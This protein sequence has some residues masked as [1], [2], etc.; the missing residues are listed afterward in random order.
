MAAQTLGLLRE[1]GQHK[2][3]DV[4]VSTV[5]IVEMVISSLL[6]NPSIYGN[7]HIYICIYKAHTVWEIRPW[8]K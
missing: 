2:V 6:G 5:A 1:I 3:L 8:L 7:I 4:H